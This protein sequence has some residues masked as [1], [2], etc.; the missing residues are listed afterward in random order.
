LLHNTLDNRLNLGLITHICCQPYRSL[1]G[2]IQ[3][4][5]GVFN[6]S[7]SDIDQGNG[8]ARFGEPF[9]YGEAY[10]PRSP[11]YDGDFTL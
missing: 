7:G 8:S 1:P 5:C 3:F 4:M 11:C 2:H 9:G 6:V 10:T